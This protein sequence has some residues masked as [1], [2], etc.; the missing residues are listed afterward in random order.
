MKQELAVLEAT[1]HPNITRVF[2]LLED[3][4]SYYVIM[5]LIS[6]GN[7]LEKVIE[8]KKLTEPI[9]ADVVNQILLS[10]SYM[11]ERKITHRD[12]K[13]E[14]LLCEVEDDNKRIN[15]KLTDFGFACFF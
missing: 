5:E 14:N 9:A 7:L 3:N 15:V 8:M 4:K 12:M 13:P 6:G 1:D 2:E 10:L 11:H